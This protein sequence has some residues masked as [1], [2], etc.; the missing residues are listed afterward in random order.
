MSELTTAQPAGTP[1]WIDLGIP[2]LDRAM[3]FYGA[4]FGWEFS[5]GS[6]ETGKYTQCLLRG[7][8]VAAIMP[9]PDRNATEFWWNLYFATDDCDATAARAEGAGG[10]ILVAPMEV[11]DQ[12]RMSIIRDPAGA[13]FGLWRAGAHIGSQIVNEPNALLR[14]DLVTPEPAPARDFYAAIFDY[15]LDANP[16]LAGADF[17]FLRRP[18]GHEIGGIFGDPKAKSS[19]WT[20]LFQVED[21]DAA[22][23]RAVD[24]GGTAAEPFDMIYGRLADITDPFGAEFQVGSPK[25]TS[26]PG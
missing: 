22:V 23:R 25:T 19:R 15:T 16:D 26:L 5:V 24:A 6:E 8:P 4:L 14:N 2:D 17:T 18:D 10:S 20:T 12:G 11:M 13:Q 1:T 9:N 7:K 3:K 21:T